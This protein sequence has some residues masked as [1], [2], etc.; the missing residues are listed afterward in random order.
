M[1]LRTF[2]SVFFLMLVALAGANLII[3]FYLGKA[4]DKKEES[5]RRLGEITSLSEDLVISS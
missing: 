2:F 3:G 4:D 5:R 1:K